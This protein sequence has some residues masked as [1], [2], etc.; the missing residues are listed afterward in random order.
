MV[1]TTKIK[2]LQYYNKFSEVFVLSLLI[3]ATNIIGKIIF[4]KLAGMTERGTVKQFFKLHIRKN[5]ER[6]L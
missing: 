4:T 3:L 1:I 2:E 5:K 6:S